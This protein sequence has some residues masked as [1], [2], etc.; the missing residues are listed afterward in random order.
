MN[1]RRSRATQES[2]RMWAFCFLVVCL[3]VILTTRV[4]LGQSSGTITGIVM[5]QTQA[6]VPNATV[7]LT[8]EGTADVRRTLSNSEGYFTF[9]ALQAKTYKLR[10]EVA[11]FQAW[12]RTGI[13]LTPGSKINISDIALQPGAQTETITVVGGSEQISPLDSGE[14][15]AVISAKEIQNTTILG[16]SAAELIKVLPGMTAVTGLDNRPGFT[17]EAIGINGNGDGGKQSA[18][19]NFSANGT[20]PSPWTSL[21]TELTFP[22]RAATVRRR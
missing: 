10:V 9:P 11:G 1:T 19:G 7:T 16:R 6:V 22:T 3:S 21:P 12:E 8:D 17:G 15:S 5:D 2:G 13:V 14:K 20:R 18:L 4:A